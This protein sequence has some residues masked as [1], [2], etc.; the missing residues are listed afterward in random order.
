MNCF[1]R[2]GFG[3]SREFA[4]ATGN[5]KTQGMCQGNG[6]APAGWTVDSIAMIQAH[7]RK[8]HRVHM[9]CPITKKSI[10]LASTLFVD[11]MDLKHLDLN[12]TEFT[13]N[14]HS[15][16]QESIINWGNLLLA[17]GGALKPAKYFYHIISFVWKPDGSWQYDS[18]EGMPKFGIIVPLGN[19]TFA[20]INHLPVTSSTKMLGQMTCP[21]R[22]SKGA[23]LQ[24]TKKA[25]KWVDRAK[26]GKLLRQNVWFLLDKQFWPG[27]S[28]GISSITASFA[29]LKQCMMHTYYDML[30]MSGVRWSVNCELCQ[31]DQGFYGCG[32]PHPGIECF[33]AQLSK[34]P[35]NYGCDSG[36]GIHL[37]NSME[38]MIVEGG[39]STQILSL[40][41]GCHSKWVTHSWLC[42]VWEKVDFFNL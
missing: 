17:T 22:S 12:K 35:T 13:A 20:P 28:F 24:M 9:Q 37:Q 31:I 14:A 4:S 15:A 10:H 26:G 16:L 41:F 3:D 11:D 19:D 18:N 6:A 23:M 25:Q 38:L 21:T 29:E 40:L 5:I 7:K 32:L 8:G 2:M 33:I 42:S 34:L 30:L 1:L 39:V 36:H 27:V